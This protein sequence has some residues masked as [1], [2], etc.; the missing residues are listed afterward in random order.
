MKHAADAVKVFVVL[1]HQ[2][3]GRVPIQGVV[4]STYLNQFVELAK[5]VELPLALDEG[6]PWLYSSVVEFGIGSSGVDTN[7]YALNKVPELREYVLREQC[8]LARERFDIPTDRFVSVLDLFANG[9]HRFLSSF[10]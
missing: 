8:P 2:A 5:E 3:L 6:K 10:L 1:E 7:Y 4:G 9:R